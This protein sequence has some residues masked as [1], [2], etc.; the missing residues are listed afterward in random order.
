MKRRL[1]VLILLSILC[2]CMCI[3]GCVAV[4]ETK[5]VLLVYMVGSD[6]ESENGLAAKDLEE[7]QK[8]FPQKDNVTLLVCLGGAKQWS[9]DVSPDVPTV[10]S[11]DSEGLHELQSLSVQSMTSPEALSSFLGYA[12]ECV[13][14]ENTALVLWDHGSGPL[15]GFGVDETADNDK[16]T[17]LEMREAFSASPYKNGNKLKWIG[18]DACLMGS[19]EMAV[20]LEPYADYLIASEE[21][22]LPCGWDYSFVSMLGDD[23][24]T[25]ALSAQILQRFYQTSVGVCGGD[26]VLMPSITLAAYDLSKSGMLVQSLEKLFEQM[27][28]TLEFGGFAQMARVRAGIDKLGRF[29]GGLTTDLVD[30]RQLIDMLLEAYPDA[31]QKALEQLDAFVVGCV[32]NNPQYA[33]LSVYFPYDDKASYLSLGKM[34]YQDISFNDAY[35][36]FVDRYANDWLRGTLEKTT[37]LHSTENADDVV[38]ELDESLLENYESARFC[39]LEKTSDGYI[40]YVS[41]N[42]VLVENGTIR[43][44]SEPKMAYLVREDT[45]ERFPIDLTYIEE[46][47]AYWFYHTPMILERYT[48]ETEYLIA[49][50]QIAVDKDTLFGMIVSAYQESED[51]YGKRQIQLD[52]WDV[53]K[54]LNKNLMPVYDANGQLLLYEQWQ[55][56]GVFSGWGLDTDAD[57][58]LEMAPIT[59]YNEDLYVQ[60][61][62]R[63]VYGNITNSDL[64]E[65]WK[66]QS[67]EHEEG[68]VEL[69]WED[70]QDSEVLLDRDDMKLEVAYVSEKLYLLAEN[71]TDKTILISLENIAVNHCM[72]NTWIYKEVLPGE[73]FMEEISIEAHSLELQLT[74]RYE[75]LQFMLTMS[76][77]GDYYSFDYQE[78]FDIVIDWPLLSQVEIPS[79]LKKEYEAPFCLKEQVLFEDEHLCIEGVALAEYRSAFENETAFFLKC[80]NKAKSIIHITLGEGY[81]NEWMYDGIGGVTLLADTWAYLEVPVNHIMIAD[82]RNVMGLTMEWYVVGDYGHRQ[83]VVLPEFELIRSSTGILQDSFF[84]SVSDYCVVEQMEFSREELLSSSTIDIQIRN[85]S[86][87]H[88]RL[89]VETFRCGGID[90]KTC[91]GGHLLYAGK[92][93]QI[94]LWFPSEDVFQVSPYK[95]SIEDIEVVLKIIDDHTGQVLDHVILSYRNTPQIKN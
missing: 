77:S 89:Y 8:Y 5:T 90:Y 83:K 29:S 18:F 75:Y 64:I 45:G 24:N 35:T 92:K 11:L 17:F 27:H 61:S 87:K 6:L 2:M 53:M 1:C 43:I 32:T 52:D 23:L 62:I 55:S 26:P 14:C 19:L 65:I 63:D 79:Y 20:M 44:N 47:D 49:E 9:I 3:F 42:D 13:P 21:V 46:N 50:L 95:Q 28:S 74:D 38:I 86:E 39:I 76:K 36:S 60:F 72:A 12:Y 33:G 4:G 80:R 59:E 30:L 16:L 54:Y 67:L 81:V 37:L 93:K 48:E 85:T 94:Q 51:S 56:V 71:R 78:Q 34:L 10:Y 25:L 7:M 88:L 15:I 82:G 91:T 58:Y 57:F 69:I 66:K 84:V 70:Q 68:P 40:K 22:E 41:S 31:A 73:R